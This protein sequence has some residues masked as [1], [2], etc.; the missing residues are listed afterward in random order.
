MLL[1]DNPQLKLCCRLEDYVSSCA[2]RLEDLDRIKL[3]LF[4]LRSSLE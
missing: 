3:Q 1:K 2:F 4:V